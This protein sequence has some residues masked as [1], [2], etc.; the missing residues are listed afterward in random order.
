MKEENEKPP[1]FGSWNRI[2]L[3]VLGAFVGL[4]IL[5]SILTNFFS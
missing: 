4:V 2:Y 3:F 1:F 5:F